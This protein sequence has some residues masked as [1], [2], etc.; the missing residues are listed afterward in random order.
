MTMSTLASDHD[1]PDHDD[2]RALAE[3]LGGIHFSP[4][5]SLGAEILAR[6]QREP[7]AAPIPPAAH[8]ALIGLALAGILLGS[9]L[10]AF[11]RLLLALAR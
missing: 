9:F 5:V 1:Q 11:W 7:T 8:V 2:I 4:R 6:L 3:T 10:F